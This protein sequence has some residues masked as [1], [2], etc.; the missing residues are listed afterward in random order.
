MFRS[1]QRVLTSA[2]LTSQQ[3]NQNLGAAGASCGDGIGRHCPSYHIL[4]QIPGL[5][6]IAL[7]FRA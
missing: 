4:A 3:C 1:S 6:G 5:E 2:Y 7:D